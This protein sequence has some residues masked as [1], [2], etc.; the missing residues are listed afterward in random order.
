MSRAS[1]KRWLYKDPSDTGD[2]PSLRDITSDEKFTEILMAV[3][4][5]YVINDVVTTHRCLRGN[6]IRSSRLSVTAFIVNFGI[7]RTTTMYDDI[8]DRG[9]GGRHLVRPNAFSNALR[10]RAHRFLH[11]RER[12]YFRGLMQ[13]G[14][15]RVTPLRLTATGQLRCTH[16]VIAYGDK[17]NR[18]YACTQGGK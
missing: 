1:R 9:E 14:C 10:Q 15:A 18:S 3:M 7:A 2:L 17:N 11:A 16:E 5:D 12:I 4:G 8:G 13:T 6:V